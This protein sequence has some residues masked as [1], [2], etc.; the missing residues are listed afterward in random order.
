MSPVIVGVD[1]SEASLRAVEWA[2]GEAVRRRL[3]LEI[4]HGFY[5]PRL[6]VPSDRRWARLSAR[7]G[8]GTPPSGSWPPRWTVRRQSRPVST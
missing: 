2:A 8:S 5:W 4:V 7:A 1:D 6:G 3:P